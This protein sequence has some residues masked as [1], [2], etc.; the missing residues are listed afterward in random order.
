[1]ENVPILGWF[2]HSFNNCISIGVLNPSC[3]LLVLIFVFVIFGILSSF[4]ENNKN[5][6]KFSI[7]LLSLSTSYLAYYLRMNYNISVIW[8]TLILISSW[9]ILLEFLSSIKMKLNKKQKKLLA[10]FYGIFSMIT[11]IALIAV[12][13][14]LLSNFFKEYF[15]TRTLMESLSEVSTSFFNTS[16]GFVYAIAVIIFLFFVC[17]ISVGI[18]FY[19]GEKISDYVNKILL[20]ENKYE[21]KWKIF[22]FVLI[23]TLALYLGSTLE[24]YFFPEGGFITYI[25]LLFSGIATLTYIS[26]FLIAIFK[27]VGNY[28]NK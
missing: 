8:V 10:N 20:I 3:G 2:L 12:V 7:L 24:R 26:Q 15:A 17:A 21:K 6:T 22:I 25:F 28:L 9:S 11:P 18:L 23:S 4:E 1:M 13:V 14:Y 5:Y 19:F 27:T 16:L